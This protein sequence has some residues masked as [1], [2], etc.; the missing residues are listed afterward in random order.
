MNESLVAAEVNCTSQGTPSLACMTE[1]TFIPP[2]FLP[3]LGCRPTPLKI[4]FENSEM[5]AESIIL[6]R[7]IHSSAPLR[8]LSEEITTFTHGY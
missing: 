8:R 3:V 5:V 1:Y 6:S 4:A 2:F 7:L